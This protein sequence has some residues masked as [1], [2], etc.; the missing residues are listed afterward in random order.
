MTSPGHATDFLHDLRQRSAAEGG[1]FW[2]DDQR[3]A[4]FE[5]AAAR[6]VSAANWR[7]LVMPDRF[8]DVVRRRRSAEV[9]WT[10]VRAAWL[11]RLRELTTAGH[12]AEL[13]ARMSRVIDAR[14]GSDVDLVMLAQ[15]VAVQSILPVIVTGLTDREHARLT[16]DVNQKLVRLVARRPFTGVLSRLRFAAVQIRAGRVVRRVLRQRATGRRPRQRD[17]ADPIVDLLPRLGMDRAMGAVTTVLTAVGGPP[18]SAAASLLYE[19]V[20][21][22][23]W[24]ERLTAELRGLDPDTFAAAPTRAAPVTYRFV[25]EVLRMWS[26]PLVLVRPARVSLDVGPA[27]LAEGCTYLLSPHVIHH[28]ERYWPDADTFDPDRFLQ[29]PAG[30]GHYVPFGWA[31]KACVGAEIGTI[32]LIALCYLMCTRY[33]L[34]VSDIDAVTMVCRFAPIPEGFRGRLSLVH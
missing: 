20:R 16:Q 2:V 5:P 19:L 18:G 30:R 14:L 24:T 21:H 11:T 31:P 27:T 23:Q 12:N 15:E 22:P 9:R 25:K 3:L 13:V 6:R 4:V 34:D 32:Q 17:L 26:P 33:Q 1:V 28:D 7:R 8:V 29:P 10:T